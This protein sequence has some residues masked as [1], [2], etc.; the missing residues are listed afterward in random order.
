MYQGLCRQPLRTAQRKLVAVPVFMRDGELVSIL[1]IELEGMIHD[2]KVLQAWSA[3]LKDIARLPTTGA[4][5]YEQ[6]MQ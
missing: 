4:H 6:G 1:A 5:P 2:V 3:K